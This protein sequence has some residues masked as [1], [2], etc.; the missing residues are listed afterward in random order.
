VDVEHQPYINLYGHMPKAYRNR[1]PLKHMLQI[2]GLVAILLGFIGGLQRYTNQQL[3]WQYRDVMADKQAAGARIKALKIQYPKITKS[4]ELQA[5]LDH[6][7]VMLQL[8]RTLLT[9][10]QVPKM[11]HE[12]GFVDVI[13]KLATHIVPYVWLREI[14]IQYGGSSIILH[15]STRQV[16]AVR[17]FIKRLSADPFFKGYA[18][19][20]KHLE[21]SAIDASHDDFSIVIALPS[22]QVAE[23]D[24]GESVS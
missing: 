17:T 20:L 9:D 7:K 4:T 6:L 14:S 12:Q 8:H 2:V 16:A 22:V 23:I 21:T 18:F 1:I 24:T 3:K 13:T 15:G 11:S 10:L 19:K 5:E